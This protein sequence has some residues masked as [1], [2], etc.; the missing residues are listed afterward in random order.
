MKTTKPVLSLRMFTVLVGFISSLGWLLDNP[1]GTS[2]PIMFMMSICLLM[3]V[4]SF[5]PDL[6][7]DHFTIGLEW[8]CLLSFS[9]LFNTLIFFGGWP[10]AWSLLVSAALGLVYYVTAHQGWLPQSLSRHLTMGWMAIHCIVLVQLIH[11]LV[12]LYLADTSFFDRCTERAYSLLVS[13]WM[14]PDGVSVFDG[15]SIEGYHVSYELTHLVW[16]VRFILVW[17]AFGLLNGLCNRRYLILGVLGAA[18]GLAAWSVVS[19]AAFYIAREPLLGLNRWLAVIAELFGIVLFVILIPGSWW[20]MPSVDA[21]ATEPYRFRWRHVAFGVG[22][23]FLAL[24]CLWYPLGKR[25]AVGEILLDDGHSTWEVSDLPFDLTDPSFSKLAGYS[26]SSFAKA[27]QQTYAVRINR[28]R[29]TAESLRGVSVLIL[30]TPTTSFIPSE[31]DAI[32]TFVKNG[33]GLFVHGDH[34]NLYGMSTILNELLQ[35]VGIEFHFDDQANFQGQPSRLM[36]GNQI[37][38]H[39][40]VDGLG[41]MQFL[42][43]CTLGLRTLQA[44]PVMIGE[45][46]FSERLNHGRPGFFGNMI[47]DPRDRYGRLVQA[48]VVPFGKGRVAAFSDS[49]LFSNF[50]LY[51]GKQVEYALRTIDYLHGTP[52]NVRLYLGITGLVLIL[53]SVLFDFASRKFTVAILGQY[54]GAFL[55]LGVTSSIFMASMLRGMDGQ[56][57]ASPDR[58][59]VDVCIGDGTIVNALMDTDPGDA[60]RLQDFGSFL[61][62]VQRMGYR[63]HLVN[64]L[65]AS[66]TSNSIIWINPKHNLQAN[67]VVRLAEEISLR[68]KKLFLVMDSNNMDTSAIELLRLLGVGTSQLTMKIE[69]SQIVPGP[70]LDESVSDGLPFLLDRFTEMKVRGQFA[71]AKAE[72]ASSLLS[73]QRVFTGGETMLWNRQGV[74]LL[75]KR[76]FVSGGCVM[77]FSHSASLS[78]LHL[79]GGFMKSLEPSEIEA[80]KSIA[81]LLT[82]IGLVQNDSDLAR[83]GKE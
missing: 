22:V 10:I 26:Y 34:T 46:I 16:A 36:L 61:T 32:R 70:P 58:S 75:T 51:S 7:P 1:L 12:Q 76:S 39:P 71:L 64:E 38:R 82:H 2:Y 13:A 59:Q 33:G 77:V 57:G 35:P 60:S 63:P 15:R 42:T 47:F 72:A 69:A 28:N 78:S 31:I 23:C 3:S 18:S 5:L 50:T 43:S 21:R 74:P 9:A 52:S 53:S 68:G 11:G 55:S 8:G 19:F 24:P 41:E 45:G 54:L 6:R 49:T 73:S 66:T 40:C 56:L 20:R 83:K 29:I 81:S 30:K 65:K 25:K 44:E 14:G 80:Q 4:A 62:V 27:L 67:E 37:Y 17:I 79:G 48:A